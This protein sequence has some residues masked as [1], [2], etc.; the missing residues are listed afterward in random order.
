MYYYYHPIQRLHFSIR[1]KKHLKE[2]T[3]KNNIKIQIDETKDYPDKVSL[4]RPQNIHHK[5]SKSF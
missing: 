4:W 2:R 3:E 5:T 1:K